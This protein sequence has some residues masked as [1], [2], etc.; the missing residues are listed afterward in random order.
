MYI[1][2]SDDR[3]HHIIGVARECYNIAKSYDK[4][5][6]FCRKMFLIGYLHDVGYEFSTTQAE[7]PDISEKIL[8]LLG[9]QNDKIGEALHAIK[10]HG[11]YTKHSTLEWKIL[12]IA[13][14]TINSKGN[15]VTVYERLE[16]IKSRYGEHSDQYLTAYDIAS[17]VG[18]IPVMDRLMRSDTYDT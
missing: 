17:Q 3:L 8:M 2:I 10:Y 6:D 18:L 5:E 1:G 11:R 9:F 7:H 15:K 12:N 14:M 4:D 16:D 13:D